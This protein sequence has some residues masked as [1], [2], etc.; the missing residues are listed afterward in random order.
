VIAEGDTTGTAERAVIDL[1]P[2]RLGR[3]YD[4]FWDRFAVAGSMAVV[5]TSFTDFLT[6]VIEAG[7]AAYWSGQALGMGDAYD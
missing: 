6:R 4:A 1:H 7:G 3:C 2:A 5:A